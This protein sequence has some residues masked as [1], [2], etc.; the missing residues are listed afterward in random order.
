MNYIFH[1]LFEKRDFFRI[2]ERRECTYGF[3]SSETHR[4]QPNVELHI[5]LFLPSL[6]YG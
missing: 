1:L 3:T 2:G 6:I 4:L 5:H